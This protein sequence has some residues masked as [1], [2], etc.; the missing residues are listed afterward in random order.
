MQYYFLQNITEEEKLRLKNITSNIKENVAIYFTSEIIN[1][2]E[3]RSTS[4]NSVNELH[5][6][7]PLITFII[8]N[9]I[10][11][12]S[13]HLESIIMFVSNLKRCHNKQYHIVLNKIND[14]S[15]NVCVYASI[16]NRD[17]AYAFEIVNNNVLSVKNG[18][19]G[20]NISQSFSK[21][22]ILYRFRFNIISHNLIDQYNDFIRDR[23]TKKYSNINTNGMAMNSRT[24]D[25]QTNRIEIV[26]NSKN[27]T[28]Q[29][30][31]EFSFDKLDKYLIKKFGNGKYEYLIDL[32][33][34]E[35]TIKYIIN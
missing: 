14:T 4:P 9:D 2:N 8:S 20:W 25:A 6:N 23:Q 31:G 12:I 7:D 21:G 26:T 15:I 28:I 16:I 5:F 24:N 3:E 1:I 11:M 17:C 30:K 10:F 27:I 22:P 19:C 29:I 32:D 35:E 18:M 34:E 13:D 33:T